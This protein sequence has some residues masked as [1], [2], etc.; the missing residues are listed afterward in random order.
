MCTTSGMKIYMGDTKTGWNESDIYVEI[1]NF[2]QRYH[3][4]WLELRFYSNCTTPVHIDWRNAI[5]NSVFEDNF[6]KFCVFF[7]LFRC[8]RCCCYCCCCLVLNFVL[9]SVGCRSGVGPSA[10]NQ[11]GSHNNQRLSVVSMRAP[12]LPC[13]LQFA[14]E[15]TPTVTPRHTHT[16]THT[17]TLFLFFMFFSFLFLFFAFVPSVCLFSKRLFEPVF[18]SFVSWV[19][20]FFLRDGSH[21]ENR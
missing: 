20:C 9:F 11:D 17:Q 1:W 15:H 6:T 19:L 5:S 7:S 14:F 18:I 3:G 4:R 8:C 16:R 12:M 10:S 13:C 2:C 21:S